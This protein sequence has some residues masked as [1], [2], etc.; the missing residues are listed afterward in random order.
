MNRKN[1]RSIFQYTLVGLALFAFLFTAHA[2][3]RIVAYVPNWVDLKTFSES[4]DYARLTH[5]NIAFEN[6]VD[7]EGNLSFKRQNDVL[8]AKAH[9]NNVKILI[10]IGGGSASGDKTLLKRYAQLLNQTNRG[11]FAAKLVAYVEKHGFD[12]L[13]VDLEGPSITPDYG[14]FIEELGK[15]FKPKGKLL[16]SALSKGYGGNNVPD[17]VFQYMD[18]VN[19]MAY[20]AVGHWDPNTRGQHSSLEFAKENIAYWLKRGLPKSK[21]VLGVPFYGYGFGEAFRNGDYSYSRI[22]AA[23]P[24]AEQADQV[25]S[26]I[27]YNGIHTI[28]AKS[29]LVVDQGLGGVMIWSL[30]YDVKGERS[31][32][33]T[34][35]TTLSATHAADM[36]TQPAFKVLAFYTGKLEQAHI[37]FVD[38][39]NQWFQRMAASNHFTYDSTTNWNQM[40]A[41]ALS[42]Y[43]VVLF[44]DSRPDDPAQRA[45]FQKYME[46]GGAWM[47][48]HFSAFALTPSQYPQNWDWYHNEFLGSGSYAGNTWKPTSAILRVEDRQHP[49]TRDLP[50]T[51]SASPNEWYKWSND[52][53]KNANIQIILSIDSSSFPLGTGPKLH[54]IW[55]SGYYPVVWTNKK[56]RMIYANMGHNDLDFSTQPNKQLSFT[57]SNEVQNKLILNSLLWLGG[58]R[59]IDN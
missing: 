43:K 33:T 37:S 51:F 16:T 53:R 9:S 34:I 18:F 36:A 24:G 50:E 13:D 6:P 45:A 17:S 38:E 15:A 7:A 20:D 23:Y 57:F 8:I 42:Q 46:N 47:G 49:A 39:A 30:D 40:N 54:E 10:S 59:V 4:I 2:E 26:T 32:L 31:L 21:V 52:L 12:G 56:Y 44:L 19:I 1:A 11:E 48:F 25:G 27:W 29:Q 14:P 41:D 22:L 35:H 3:S 55:H 5:I 28:K 58:S